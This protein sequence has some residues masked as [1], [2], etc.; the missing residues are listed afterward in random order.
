MV[1][2]ISTLAA[3]SGDIAMGTFP[4]SYRAGPDRLG[5]GVDNMALVRPGIGIDEPVYGP[6]YNVRRSFEPF[7]GAAQFPLAVSGPATDLRASGVYM[8][9]DMAL[10]ALA[11]FQKA[12]G[13]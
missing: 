1:A 10:A 11:D 3:F 13:G 7:R 2:S 12:H 9:G 8:S 4:Y 5:I 6:R